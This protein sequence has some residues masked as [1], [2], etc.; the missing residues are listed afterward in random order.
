MLDVT[1]AVTVAFGVTRATAVAVVS[2]GAEEQAVKIRMKSAVSAGKTIGFLGI[3]FPING[4]LTPLWLR[5]DMV[6]QR[7][8]MSGI[9]W[10]PGQRV[11]GAQRSSPEMLTK[12]NHLQGAQKAVE[13]I[14]GMSIRRKQAGA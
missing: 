8:S 9:L 11:N 7:R 2:A 12:Q 3:G 5:S 6:C 1:T 10:F 4:W 14:S 13:L